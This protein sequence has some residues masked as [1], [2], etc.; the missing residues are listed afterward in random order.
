MVISPR[1]REK[2]DD[3]KDEYLVVYHSMQKG[4][5]TCGTFEWDPL[6]DC[7]NTRTIPPPLPPRTTTNAYT[8]L[9]L[10]TLEGSPSSIW[11]S[12]GALRSFQVS[13][14]RTSK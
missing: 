12:T 9:R 7:P 13:N 14:E 5:F 11:P 10:H 2:K 6:M 4:H 1:E 8:T 3:K